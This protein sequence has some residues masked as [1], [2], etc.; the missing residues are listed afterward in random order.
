MCKC[1]CKEIL[2]LLSL[3]PLR[4]H[5]SHVWSITVV[6]STWTLNHWIDR[7]LEW[8]VAKTCT[9]HGT[10]ARRLFCLCGLIDNKM[11]FL[12]V[13]DSRKLFFY[14]HHNTAASDLSLGFKRGNVKASFKEQL[15]GMCESC[16]ICFRCKICCSWWGGLDTGNRKPKSTDSH[17]SWQKFF[18]VQVWRIFVNVMQQQVGGGSAIRVKGF[19]RAFIFSNYFLC[20]SACI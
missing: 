9:F 18:S 12:C 13:G 15:L 8:Q 10:T 17:L 19:S 4:A 2:V 7:Y 16:L 3:R 20:N 14:L 11:V 1:L 5:N 6:V